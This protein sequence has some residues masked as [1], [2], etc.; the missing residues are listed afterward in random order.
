M[1]HNT[2]IKGK[3]DEAGNAKLRVLMKKLYI[4][5]HETSM[6]LVHRGF[7]FLFKKA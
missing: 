3:P 4:N 5:L 7:I 2:Y 1:N 6:R